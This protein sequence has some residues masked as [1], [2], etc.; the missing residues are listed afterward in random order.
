MQPQL[1]AQNRTKATCLV[2]VKVTVTMNIYAFGS[3][4]DWSWSCK[5]LHYLPFAPF[6]AVAANHI[7]FPLTCTKYPIKL[8]SVIVGSSWHKMHCKHTHTHTLT[9]DHCKHT[10]QTQGQQSGCLCSEAV[11][12]PTTLKPQRQQLGYLIV[13]WLMILVHKPHTCTKYPHKVS[14][15]NGTEC[16]RVDHGFAHC[17]SQCGW[18]QGRVMSNC[19]LL[20]TAPGEHNLT[21]L[22]VVGAWREENR[23][24]GR[25]QTQ[26]L[27]SVQTF[28]REENLLNSILAKVIQLA[29]LE[30][31]NL[32]FLQ[33]L[34]CS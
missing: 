12:V 4:P 11:P 18:G 22:L 7:W 27:L 8:S 5:N 15:Y 13:M 29:L 19:G 2:D 3:V 30:V 14:T 9:A 33:I 16:D 28:H 20:H 34:T 17:L 23:R 32:I 31:P 10:E 1:Q 6:S 24:E 21:L 25:K 26:W